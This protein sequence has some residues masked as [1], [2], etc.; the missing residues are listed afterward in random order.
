[1]SQD[2]L[3]SEEPALLDRLPAWGTICAGGLYEQAI[4]QLLI[5]V[6]DGSALLGTPR[7]IK[8]LPT[9]SARDHKDYGENVNWKR[10]KDRSILPG[11]IMSWRTKDGNK[12]PEKK[13]QN[14]PHDKGIEPA[15]VEWMMGLPEGWV[16]G[17]GLGRTAELKML[18]NGVVPMQGELA[19][20][21][22]DV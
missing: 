14:Q 6:R 9:P 11:T 13:H 16:T 1:M 2:T 4:P 12:T 5:N 15:F 8:L 20:R 21:L 17:H 3:L 18:G 7:A 22:L 19:L 10:G